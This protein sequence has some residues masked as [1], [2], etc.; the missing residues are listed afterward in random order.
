MADI[1]T[2]DEEGPKINPDLMEP[3]R[4]YHCIYRDKVLLFFV[5]EQKFLNCYEIEEPDL[6]EKIRNT[7]DIEA[8]LEE[9]AC[10]LKS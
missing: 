9:Y 4:I 5:D 7:H 10:A 1:I 8:A 6:V 2:V 3:N